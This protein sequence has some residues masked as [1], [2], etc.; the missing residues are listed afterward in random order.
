V[1]T[2][3]REQARLI[4]RL[5]SDERF[6][7]SFQGVRVGTPHTFQG[8]ESET[9]LFSTVLA[10]EADPATAAWLDAERDLINLAVSRARKRLL[11][12]G[13]RVQLRRLGASTL[14][15]LAEAADRRVRRREPAPSEVTVALH[16][17]LVAR[18]IPASLGSV[19]EGY[20]LAITLIGADGHRIDV[21]VDEFPEGDPRGRARRQAAARDANLAELGWTVI[22]IPA[23]RAALEPR[24]VADAVLAAAIG[25]S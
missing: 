20:P 8:G 25:K 21:E 23:W 15:A 22:R 14:L 13:D 24:G 2:P 19:D 17:A 7:A 16:A 11:V 5:L 12:F 3:F 1:V 9:V 6:G 4:R 18:G 10:A